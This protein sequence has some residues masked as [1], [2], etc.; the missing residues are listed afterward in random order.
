MYLNA[1]SHK[2]DEDDWWQTSENQ[3]SAPEYKG[4][5]SKI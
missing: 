5:V 3:E 2:D 4:R 1:V